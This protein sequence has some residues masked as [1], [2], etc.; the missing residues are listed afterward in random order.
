MFRKFA[1]DG[2]FHSNGKS[3]AILREICRNIAVLQ[4]DTIYSPIWLSS[5]WFVDIFI[6]SHDDEVRVSNLFLTV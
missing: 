2:H 5:Y 3:M 1:I 6:A 4:R